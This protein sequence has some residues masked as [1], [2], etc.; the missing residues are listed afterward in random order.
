M[1]NAP[2]SPASLGWVVDQ[3]GSRERSWIVGHIRS[4]GSCQAKVARE[5]Y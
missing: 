1:G 5:Y 4:V 3:G 2:W